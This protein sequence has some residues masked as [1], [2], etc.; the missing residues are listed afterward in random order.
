LD[1]ACGDDVEFR[2]RVEALLAAH[3][4]ADSMLDADHGEPLASTTAPTHSSKRPVIGH[5]VVGAC[6]DD[7]NMA[8]EAE[9][10]YISASKGD[11]WWAWHGY[12]LLREGRTEEARV[13]MGRMQSR[14]TNRYGKLWKQ[15]LIQIADIIDGRFDRESVIHLAENLE[16][17]ET[18][19]PIYALLVAGDYES[20]EKIVEPIGSNT[21]HDRMMLSLNHIQGDFSKIGSFVE[22]RTNSRAKQR[23]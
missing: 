10:A 15:L 4:N 5:V 13:F 17:D 1:A 21:Y 20:A 8:I 23:L 2:K 3:E 14:E 12:Q 7:L 9:H 16:A 19:L 22:R 6:Y 11:D 18:S